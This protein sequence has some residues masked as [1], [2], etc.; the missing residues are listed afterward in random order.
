MVLAPHFFFAQAGFGAAYAVAEDVTDFLD[1][2]GLKI[3]LVS[4]LFDGK[5]PAAAAAAAPAADKPKGILGQIKTL[6]FGENF[7][8]S[9][10]IIV[11]QNNK[12]QDKPPFETAMKQWMQDSGVGEVFEEAKQQHSKAMKEYLEEIENMVMPILDVTKML[13]S[14]KTDSPDEIMAIVNKAK[15]VGLPG[16]DQFEQKLQAIIEKIA[17]DEQFEKTA[18]ELAQEKPGNDGATEQ[19]DEEAAEDLTIAEFLA[20]FKKS[21]AGEDGI[22]QLQKQALQAIEE[23]EPDDFNK[24]ALNTTAYGKEYLAT[25]NATKQKIADAFQNLVV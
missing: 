18:D 10:P 23:I 15:E 11:E 14:A 2:A 9:L 8:S 22:A 20:D 12:K 7:T 19:Q 17:E 3:P 5:A 21:A 13:I 16:A 4:S 24:Q 6:F 1:G 25:I